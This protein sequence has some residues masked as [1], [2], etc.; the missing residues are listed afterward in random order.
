M[1]TVF[2]KNNQNFAQGNNKSSKYFLIPE[3]CIR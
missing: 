1:I 2:L 3:Q